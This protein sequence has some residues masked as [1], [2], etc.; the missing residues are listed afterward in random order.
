M[1]AL[2]TLEDVLRG[3]NE[4]PDPEE[5]DRVIAEISAARRLFQSVKVRVGA[6]AAVLSAPA[7]FLVKGK[8]IGDAAQVVIDAITPLLGHI[9]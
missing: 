5:K 1:S 6:V 8:A 2:E 7:F 4:Y 9:F 3:S